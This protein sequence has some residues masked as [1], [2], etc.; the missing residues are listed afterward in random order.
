MHFT[1]LAE[2]RKRKLL[3]KLA[4]PLQAVKVLHD[5]IGIQK[6]LAR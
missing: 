5:G 6:G 2:V 3:C 4:I 1:V